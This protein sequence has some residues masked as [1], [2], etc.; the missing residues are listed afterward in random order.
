M[1]ALEPDAEFFRRHLRDLL[2][3]ALAHFRA[4]VIEMD[5]AVLIDVDQRAG[6]IEVRQRKGNAEFHRRQRD[7]ALQNR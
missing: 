7:A 5:R 1:H 3:Q 6:L 2:K 4:A